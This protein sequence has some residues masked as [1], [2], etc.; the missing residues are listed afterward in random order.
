MWCV[1][2]LNPPNENCP[3]ETRHL[4]VKQ[5]YYYSEVQPYRLKRIG[6]VEASHVSIILLETSQVFLD[7]RSSIDVDFLCHVSAQSHEAL[8]ETC[9]S[10]IPP[11]AN[12]MSAGNLQ[13]EMCRN[14]SSHGC[15]P[16]EETPL[17]W[18]SDH[19]TLACPAKTSPFFLKSWLDGLWI[20]EF[21][22]DLFLKTQVSGSTTSM[23]L[24]KL[25]PD[26]EYTVTV[27]PV[28]P[29]MEGI[30]QSEKGKTSKLTA[31]DSVEHSLQC[32]KW[33]KDSKMWSFSTFPWRFL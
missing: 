1:S 24:Q 29:E 20:L 32:H 10:T 21:I 17:W 27:V 9:R 4:A 3:E 13:R 11:P 8:W 14:T 22:W 12:S 25:D 30:S 26:T 33:L 7:S 18:D 15:R 5:I 31:P 2:L 6:S 16:R 28:Y 19:M 23:V